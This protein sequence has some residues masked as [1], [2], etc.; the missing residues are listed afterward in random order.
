MPSPLPLSGIRVLELAEGWAGPMTAMWLGDLG[1]EVLKIEA[2]QRYD[3]ARGQVNESRAL[4]S[5][6]NKSPGARPYDVAGAY[7]QAN[8]NKRDATIDLSR[9]KGIALFKELVAISDVV[10]TNMVTGVPEKMGIGYRDLAKVRPDLIM[11]ISSG[12]GATGP[13]AKRVTMGGAMDGIAG[14]TWL[15]HYPDQTPDTAT[16]SIHTDVVTG[17]NNSMAV[18]MALYH[19]NKTGKG[20]LIETSGVEAS[21][22]QIHVSLMDYALNERVR[23][24][25]GNGHEAMAPHGCYPCAGEDRW[26]NI[27]VWSEGQWRALCNMMGDPGWSREAQFATMAGRLKHQGALNSHMAKW[28]RGQEQM[29]L[30]H[31]L[32]R[33]GVPAGAVYD[34]SQIGTDP[35]FAARGAFQR[36]TLTGYGDYPIPTSPWTM[37]GRHIGAR[38]PPPM[39]AEHNG[40]VFGE[41]LHLPSA[42]I[43]ALRREEYIGERPV[44]KAI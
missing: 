4:P 22:H 8:R 42:A 14:F 18:Q 41:L 27:T 30:M 31:R 34:Q 11:L 19:R 43:E 25:H 39:L 36:V 6:P 24:A 3:H 33:A 13:Y 5:Y 2:I 7:V 23:T 32:Q 28:T 12:Y 9:A 10:V 21:L 37:D 26:I 38:L 40:Y 17:M 29:E 16:F 15:R 1:A 44:Q 35:H 20:Q